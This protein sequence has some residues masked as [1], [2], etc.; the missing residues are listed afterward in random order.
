MNDRSNDSHDCVADHVLQYPVRA[1]SEERRGVP[2][3][4]MATPLKAAIIAAMLITPLG[5]AFAGELGDSTDPQKPNGPQTSTRILERM[6]A[7]GQKPSGLLASPAAF[8]HWIDE[9][10]SSHVAI[11]VTIAR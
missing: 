2:R 4:Q 7:T 3:G 10:R 11:A 5:A 1:S 9:K 6:P 8:A